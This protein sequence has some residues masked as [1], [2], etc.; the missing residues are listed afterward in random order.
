[1]KKVIFIERTGW[2]RL[3]KENIR[4]RDEKNYFD[5]SNGRFVHW[6]VFMW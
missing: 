5:I 6:F 4:R 1:L 2:V 3:M